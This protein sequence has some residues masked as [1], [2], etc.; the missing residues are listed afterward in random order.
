ME[1]FGSSNK[2]I[3]F[4]ESI[5]KIIKDYIPKMSL[6]LVNKKE[7]M[8]KTYS[9]VYLFGD[10]LYVGTRSSKLYIYKINGPEL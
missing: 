9:C 1:M 5:K 8:Q 4:N 10:T 6:K 3:D 2:V 7:G